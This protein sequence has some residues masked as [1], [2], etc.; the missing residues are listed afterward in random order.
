MDD[1][2]RVRQSV[3]WLRNR[4][5]KSVALASLNAVAD[6]AA[7]LS[8]AAADDWVAPEGVAASPFSKTSAD[9]DV[10]AVCIVDKANFP[11]LMRQLERIAYKNKVIIPADPD[12][13][14]NPWLKTL[15]M[16]TSAW[17][18]AA[19]CPSTSRFT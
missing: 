5:A 13:V 1:M 19:R 9:T 11:T 18:T 16:E 17:H 3:D 15:T 8:A 12:W 7:M 6:P 4:G 2:M 14:V 10:D